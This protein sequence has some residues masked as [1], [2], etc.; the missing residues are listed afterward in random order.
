MSDALGDGNLNLPYEDNPAPASL[1]LADALVAG[2]L[3]VMA[4][5]LPLDSG[6]TMPALVFRFA[7][8][9]GTFMPPIVFACSPAEM[10]AVLP[11]VTNTV[12]ASLRAAAAAPGGPTRA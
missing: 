10:R 2:G 3:V 9:T 11:L 5:T 8:A 4:A 12:K 6:S 1:D 7:L